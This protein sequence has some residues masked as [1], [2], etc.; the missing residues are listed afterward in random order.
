MVRLTS[1]DSLLLHFKFK[2]IL[3]FF[4]LTLIGCGVNG[5]KEDRR[6]TEEEL[7]TPSVNI[8]ASAPS[9]N[10]NTP[11][12]AASASDDLVENQG[13]TQD[14]NLSASP[15]KKD[16][17]TIK[18]EALDLS[19]QT[20]EQGEVLSGFSFQLVDQTGE[21]VGDIELS[22]PVE[23]NVDRSKDDPSVEYA[24]AFRK[25]TSDAFT[26]LPSEN[27]SIT[28]SQLGKMVRLNISAS[29]GEIFILT[30]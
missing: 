29:L 6:L 3:C 21:A 24:I 11:V 19:S 16:D 7:K 13:A 28:E 14:P 25:T 17:Y 10:S 5:G 15:T 23:L 27:V 8:E 1:E 9:Q 22:G 26:I 2:M 4:S 20:F 18:V 30:P 12:K